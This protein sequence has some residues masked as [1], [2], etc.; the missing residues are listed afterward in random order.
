MRTFWGFVLGCLLFFPGTVLVQ[1][2]IKSLGISMNPT[3]TDACMAII[4]VLLTVFVVQ[5]RPE[6]AASPEPR[7]RRSWRQATTGRQPP[8]YTDDPPTAPRRPTR[9]PRDGDDRR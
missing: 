5:H 6:H 7:E 1:W 9:R 4:M 3:V 8:R 2:T